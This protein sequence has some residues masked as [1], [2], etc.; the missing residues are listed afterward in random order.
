MS[1]NNHELP[2]GYPLDGYDDP[3][4]VPRDVFDV[5]IVWGRKTFGPLLDDWLDP[6]RPTLWERLT[7]GFYEVEGDVAG[8]ETPPSDDKISIPSISDCDPIA[9][10]DWL[11]FIE[12][13]PAQVPS[14]ETGV[15]NSE[16]KA[17]YT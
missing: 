14:I 15:K 6:N 8:V 17:E 10:D 12:P 3:R 2:E 1:L 4:F 11:K 5:L 16:Y 7:A 13:I 9:M